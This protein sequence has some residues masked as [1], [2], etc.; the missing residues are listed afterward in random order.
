MRGVW[1]AA[2]FEWV[3][4]GGCVAY[5][6][7]VRA[8]GLGKFCA[9]Q[10]ITYSSRHQVLLSICSLLTDANPADPLVAN[11]AQQYIADRLGGVTSCC[12]LFVSL[13]RRHSEAERDR[14]RG[15]SS[16]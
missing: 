11:I 8:H 16:F 10:A 13:G 6:R 1:L 9:E 7:V 5:G 14:L 3:G 4:T 2:I 15:C 12:L